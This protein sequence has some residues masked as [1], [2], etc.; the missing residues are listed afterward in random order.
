MGI[1][2]MDILATEGVEYR[3]LL[4]SVGV[5]AEAKVYPGCTHSLLALDGIY[6]HFLTS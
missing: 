2:E 5:K 6:P 4:R 1:S 3:D